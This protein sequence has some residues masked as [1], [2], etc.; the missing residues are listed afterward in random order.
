MQVLHTK[1]GNEEGELPVHLTLSLETSHSPCLKMRENEQKDE[2]N[3]LSATLSCSDN[4]ICLLLAL[5]LKDGVYFCYWAYFLCISR[6]S[7]FLC[8]VPTNTGIFFARF[9]TLQK[10]QN[11]AST[12]GIQKQNWG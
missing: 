1:N 4:N 7:G 9:Y 11:L 6:Y 12:L 5:C 8:V 2:L 3:L 10:K